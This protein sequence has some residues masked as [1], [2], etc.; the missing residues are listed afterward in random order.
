ML[1]VDY[2]NIRRL[3]T[4]KRLIAVNGMF[5]GPTVYANEGD[6]LIIK[7]TNGIKE[8]IAIHW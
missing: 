1:Q 6:R 3:N 7:V 2:M 5:P 4:K 8:D